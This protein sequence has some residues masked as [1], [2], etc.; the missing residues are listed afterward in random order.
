MNQKRGSRRLVVWRY[1]EWLCEYREAET[2][3]LHLYMGAESVESVTVLDTFDAL[4]RSA[5]W[6]NA[7]RG[8]QDD[9]EW[10][11]PLAI[12]PN[13]RR[14]IAGGGRRRGDA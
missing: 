4:E 13:R 3:T 11:A 12:Q 1:S 7:V 5:R 8:P 14:G 6:K 9:G 2:P 10:S